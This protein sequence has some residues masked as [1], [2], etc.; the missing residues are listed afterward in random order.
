MISISSVI[1]LVEKLS[2]KGVPLAELWKEKVTGNP[3]FDFHT[4]SPE[5][6][7]AFGEAKYRSNSNAYSDAAKQVCDFIDLAKD[8]LDLNNLKNFSQEAALKLVNDKLRSFTVAFSMHS[9]NYGAIFNN[10][11]S[12]EFIKKIS[13]H[14][15]ELYLIGVK[16]A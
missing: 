10:A 16:H 11:V 8:D 5:I 9:D 1:C 12:N 6:I 2:H 13:T 14:A 15:Q 4:I 3:G 7:F